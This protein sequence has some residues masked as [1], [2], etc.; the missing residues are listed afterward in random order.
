M[1]RVSFESDLGEVTPVFFFFFLRCLGIVVNE[2]PISM[3]FS[4]VTVQWS[5][6][7]WCLV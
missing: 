2:M 4:S 6:Y 5:V 1:S 7:V 3:L